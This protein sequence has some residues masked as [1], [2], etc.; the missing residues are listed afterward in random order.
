MGQD[1]R[2]AMTGMK[3]MGKGALSSALRSGQVGLRLRMSVGDWRVQKGD[4]VLSGRA[5]LVRRFRVLAET[6]QL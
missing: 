3:Q 5:P 4:K 2:E 6:A 1:A